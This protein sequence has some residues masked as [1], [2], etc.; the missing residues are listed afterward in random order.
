MDKNSFLFRTIQ[1]AKTSTLED[2]DKSTYTPMRAHIGPLHYIS[3]KHI[4]L[5][6]AQHAHTHSS[7][8]QDLILLQTP[9]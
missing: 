7:F 2:T 6:Y 5:T 4:L 9:T 8:S 3:H 1:R